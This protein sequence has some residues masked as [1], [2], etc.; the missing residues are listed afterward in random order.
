MGSE[1]H[2]DSEKGVLQ[3]RVPNSIVVEE[4]VLKNLKKQMHCNLQRKKN[5]CTAEN[6]A[7]ATLYIKQLKMMDG[8]KVE[9]LRNNSLQLGKKLAAYAMV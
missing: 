3:M 2:S 1:T 4:R 9:D 6:E 8:G 5:K 7:A